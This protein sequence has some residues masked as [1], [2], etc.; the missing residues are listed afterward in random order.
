MSIN[1]LTAGLLLVLSPLAW[2]SNLSGLWQEYDDDTGK[3]AALIRI[4]SEPDGSYSGIIEKVFPTTGDVAETRCVH[5]TGDLHNRPLLGMRILSGMKRKDKLNYEGGEV[6]DPDDGKTYRCHMQLSEDE[7]TLNVTGYINIVW[8][9]Q[10]E[11]WLR[12][13]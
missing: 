9:G 12:V 7:N 8:I 11:I 10:S 4:E 1:R 13:R 6:L 2:G 5:C 3:L